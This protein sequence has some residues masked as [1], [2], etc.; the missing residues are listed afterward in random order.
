MTIYRT[1]NE[2]IHNPL[3]KVPSKKGCE[4]LMKAVCGTVVH[5]SFSL[6]REST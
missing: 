6:Y 1:G 4:A 2:V 5:H 3:D